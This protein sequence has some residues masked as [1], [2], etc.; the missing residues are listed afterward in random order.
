MFR[1]ELPEHATR[2]RVRY[3]SSRGCLVARR[4]VRVIT[5][6]CDNAALRFAS[7][8]VIAALAVHPSRVMANLLLPSPEVQLIIEFQE[9]ALQVLY[10][11]GHRQRA[12]CARGHRW[13][14]GDRSS[15]WRSGCGSPSR[16][17]GGQVATGD[18]RSRSDA[19][20]LMGKGP[21]QPAGSV[22]SVRISGL[23]VRSVVWRYAAVT[24]AVVIVLTAALLMISATPP[25]QQRQRQT[26]RRDEFFLAMALPA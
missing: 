5:D 13:S 18:I 7:A 6:P 2:A 4:S 26:E 20:Y 24:A 17:R 14:A 1:G 16:I 3:V 25:A 22:V 12:K 9:D 19:L 10:R 21:A 11:A 15:G 23:P 8:L